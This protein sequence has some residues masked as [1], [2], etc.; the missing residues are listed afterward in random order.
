[1]K[2]LGVTLGLVVLL[3]ALLLVVAVPTFAG[4]NKHGNDQDPPAWG[5][6]KNKHNGGDQAA[7][8]QKAK[9]KAGADDPTVT[10]PITAPIT[11][12]V[13]ITLCH[14]PGTPAEKT[15]VLPAAA[16][17]G[18]LRHGDYEGVCDEV[19]GT[20]TATEMITICHKPGTPAEK[21]LVLP[22][23]AVPGHLR[24]GDYEGVCD[25]VTGTITATEM[26]TICHK[27]GTPAEKTLVLPAAAL[28][29]HTQHGDELG[30]C[31]DV[32]AAAP[33]YHGRER[34]RR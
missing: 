8:G 23:A 14:K 19:T 6:Q 7:G 22:A 18:H 17:P 26:I 28:F 5:H 9:D 4:K 29:G 32:V 25:E 34:H 33:V 10:T 11:Y 16:V 20:I 2:G 27:P 21:T 12:T 24:H 1:M 15:L 13:M 31:P 3:S 30:A